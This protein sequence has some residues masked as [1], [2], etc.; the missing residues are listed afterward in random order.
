MTT[1]SYTKTS[2]P[3]A[4]QFASAT[5]HLER[6]SEWRTVRID[7]VRYISLVSGRSNRVYLARADAAGCSCT[8][9][10]TMSSPCSHRIAIELAALEDELAEETTTLAELY[11]RCARVGCGAICENR[12]CDDCAAIQERS[13]RLA[14]ARARVALEV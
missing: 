3:T 11:P 14:A 9:S 6:R 10:Q 5:T 1:A 4:S 8:W 12:L 13:E 7:G 2:A